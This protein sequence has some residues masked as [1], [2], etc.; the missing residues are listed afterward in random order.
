[1]ELGDDVLKPFLQD[2]IQ[3]SALSKT[4]PSVDPK[5]VLPLL[6]RIGLPM[7]LDW[8]KHYVNLGLYGSLYSLGQSSSAIARRLSPSQQY[9]YHRWL[10]AWKYGSGRDYPS[11]DP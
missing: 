4:L 10:D 11:C 7:L 9:Y 3:F 1:D 6:P 5:L 2:T 8:L